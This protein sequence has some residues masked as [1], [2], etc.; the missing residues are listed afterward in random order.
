MDKQQYQHTFQQLC[1]IPGFCGLGWGIKEVQ[2]HLTPAIAWRVYVQRKQPLQQCS[3]KQWIPAAIDGIPTDVIEL[4]ATHITGASPSGNLIVNKKG[5]PG[6]LGCVAFSRAEQQYVFL[7]NYHVLF[8][9]GAG[10]SDRVWWGSDSRDTAGLMPLGKTLYGKIGTVMFHEEEYYI[11]CAIGTMNDTAEYSETSFTTVTPAFPGCVVTKKGVATGLSSGIVVDVHYPDSAFINGIA[12][13]TP[14]QLLIKPVGTNTVF[15]AKGDSGALVMD[16]Q[17]K[18]VG[19]LWGSNAK[20]EGVAAHL[21]PILHELDI[22]ICSPVV[23]TVSSWKQW[24]KKVYS[25]FK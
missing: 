8:S 17:N 4:S 5:I 21:G 1:H 22:V 12:Y 14:N 23:Y 15:S 2:C 25:V 18:G 19:L 3:R 20:G 6:T 9:G 10:E 24:M 11:D 13:N 16:E 7:T